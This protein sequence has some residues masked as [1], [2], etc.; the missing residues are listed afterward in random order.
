MTSFPKRLPHWF[1][2]PLSDLQN[3]KNLL[4]DINSLGINTVCVSGRC[5]NKGSCFR[6]KRLTF[7]IMGSI[8]TRD[9][10]F[11]AVKKGIPEPLN[12]EEPFNIVKQINKLNLKFIV[13]TSVTR[14]DLE[15]GGASFFHQTIKTIKTTIHN[16]KIELLIPDFQGSKQ[17][18]DTILSSPPNVFGHNLE[19]IPRL[20]K[21]VRPQADYKTSLNLLAYVKSKN[22]CVLTK[23]GIMVGLGE[24]KD[25]I[26]E[27]MKDVVRVKCD[28][29]TLGQY[30]QPDR[31]CVEVKEYI[32]PEIFDEYCKIGKDLGIK[33]IYAG[34]LIRSSYHA[35][36]EYYKMRSNFSPLKKSATELFR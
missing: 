17:A 3:T 23:T 19:T 18:I 16:V 29:F 32:H 28:F 35:E 24:K 2:Q 10:K 7:M 15:D 34:P 11:C 8:C 31:R 20:Y 30:L 12:N 36:D 6:E 4:K 33:N 9:C 14:D 21:K 13:M 5:P 27:L 22:N 26:I 1:K 25:E